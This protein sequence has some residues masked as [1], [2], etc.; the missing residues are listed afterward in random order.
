[1]NLKTPLVRNDERGK[2]G[3][4]STIKKTK[5]TTKNCHPTATVI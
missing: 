4:Y 5:T 1:M 2:G 3:K